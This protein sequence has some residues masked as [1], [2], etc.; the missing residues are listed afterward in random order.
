MDRAE[1][2]W[3]RFAAVVAGATTFLF[4]YGALTPFRSLHLSAA[5]GVRR[6]IREFIFGNSVQISLIDILANFLVLMP[7]GCILA[8]AFARSKRN[9][10]LVLAKAVMSVAALSLAVEFTQSWFFTR[11]PSLLDWILNT[12]GGYFGALFAIYLRSKFVPCRQ[13][14]PQISTAKAIADSN[15]TE[16]TRLLWL[17][18]FGY[19]VLISL[20]ELAPFRTISSASVGWLKLRE[21]WA[22]PLTSLYLIP[23]HEIFLQGLLKVLLLIPLGFLVGLVGR[24]TQDDNAPIRTRGL[25]IDPVILI[26]GWLVLLELA[27]IFIVSRIPQIMD[28]ALYLAGYFLGS[29]VVS[30]VWLAGARTEHARGIAS[31]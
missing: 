7:L 16:I 8:V 17:L 10:G 13:I 5:D 14:A 4:V 19:I 29:G 25:V 26:L 18:I 20:I 23:P 24:F 12:I 2:N 3:R 15:T 9:N 27:Q 22:S 30:A 31:S 11:V 1:Q 6:F 21:F 28:L